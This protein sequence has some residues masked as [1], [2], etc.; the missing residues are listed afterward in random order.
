[1][2][3]SFKGKTGTYLSYLFLTNREKVSALPSVVVEKPVFKCSLCPK[4]N[5][6]VL[7]KYCWLCFLAPTW[8]FP[9]QSA[10]VGTARLPSPVGFSLSKVRG[11]GDAGKSCHT[12]VCALWIVGP[13]TGDPEQDP[14]FLVFLCQPLR[15]AIMALG[16]LWVLDCR[17]Y[18]KSTGSFF[19][20]REITAPLF[21]GTN[22]PRPE[23]MLNPTQLK[24]PTKVSQLVI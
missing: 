21:Y 17:V 12:S 9:G 5:L 16:F 23:F 13:L 3:W 20:S 4:T 6:Q 18:L 19:I 10:R 2:S 11:R 24:H 8:T 22:K 7:T 15:R 14:S 1:M